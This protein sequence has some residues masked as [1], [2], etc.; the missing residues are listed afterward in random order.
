MQT[1]ISNDAYYS[2]YLLILQ[3]FKVC[4]STAN[5]F[6]LI[7][8][9]TQGSVCDNI[10]ATIRDHLSISYRKDV[11]IVEV[12]K[13]YILYSF[14]FMFFILLYNNICLDLGSFIRWYIRIPR[15]TG[16][17]L[18]GIRLN[19]LERIECSTLF[20]K[21]LKF[22]QIPPKILISKF[23]PTYTASLFAKFLQLCGWVRLLI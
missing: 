23:F 1:Y 9:H 19:H 16:W 15:E 22:L 5:S 12:M 21:C 4:E 11:Q 8:S 18:Q 3:I 6:S 17:S 14:I 20:L 7:F 2:L 13:W 10:V